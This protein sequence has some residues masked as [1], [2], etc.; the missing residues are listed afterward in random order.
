MMGTKGAY[1]ELIH[2]HFEHKA[3][4]TL[5]NFRASARSG[6]RMGA[7]DDSLPRAM[8]TSDCCRL[9]GGSSVSAGRGAWPNV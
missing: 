7:I 9:L 2:D 1:R 3:N 8:L 5:P 6:C 4:H